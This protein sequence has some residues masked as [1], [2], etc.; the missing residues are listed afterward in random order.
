MKNKIQS[1]VGKA[2]D[3]KLGD[4]V[5]TFTCSKEIQSGN[6]DFATQTYPVI[7]VEAYTGRGVLFGSYLKDMVKPTDYQV[8]DCKAIVLQNEVTQVPQ[9][10]DVW[11]TSKGRFKL[12]NI[13]VDSVSATYTAQL[14]K[15]SA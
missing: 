4:A 1:K 2:F 8:T 3:K 10:G 9:I 12:V 14:R 6:F 11:T 5:D 7:T 13:G 15:V